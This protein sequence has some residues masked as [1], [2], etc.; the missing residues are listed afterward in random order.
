MKR[1]HGWLRASLAVSG[2]LGA[3]AAGPAQGK[4]LFP[5]GVDAEIEA[6]IHRGLDF[7]ARSQNRDGSWRSEGRQG[8]YPCAMTG[9]AGMALLGGGSTP[10]RGRNWRPVRR[11]V[12]FLISQQQPSGLIT[13]PA[14][15]GQSMYGHGFS[16]MFLAEVYGM[17]EDERRQQDLHR[18]L[19]Q[20]VKLIAQAQ[21]PSG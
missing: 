9:L 4:A 14:E 6:A 19:V 20:A 11:C 21:S 12:D 1:R 15:E 2:V 7:L 13:A 17:E 5:E 3:A 8:M 16:T 18:V 10:T